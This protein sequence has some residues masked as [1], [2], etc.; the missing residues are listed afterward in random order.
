MNISNII[1]F[2]GSLLFCMKTQPK[3]VKKKNT[4][5]T[6]YFISFYILYFMKL[7]QDKI[8]ACVTKLEYNKINYLHVNMEYK[9]INSKYRLLLRKKEELKCKGC[10]Q[11]EQSSL[12]SQQVVIYFMQEH[13]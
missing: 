12:L 4:K 1:F 11:R 9:V 2:V 8:S 13:A 6:K 5:Y 10:A 3:A 7:Y